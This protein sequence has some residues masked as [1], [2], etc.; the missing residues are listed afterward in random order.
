MKK[1]ILLSVLTIGMTIQSVDAMRDK[2]ESVAQ[3]RQLSVE[4]KQRAKELMG[5]LGDAL[6]MDLVMNS[7]QRRTVNEVIAELAK[8]LGLQPVSLTPMNAWQQLPDFMERCNK[9]LQKY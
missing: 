4:N 1:I 7:S 5:Q 2:A 9:E 3:T 8:I 6:E